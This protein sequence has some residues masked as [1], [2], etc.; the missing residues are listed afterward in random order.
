MPILLINRF[1]DL[2]APEARTRWLAD[3][4]PNCAGYHVVS[5]GERFFLYSEAAR[6]NSLIADFL[7]CEG[8]EV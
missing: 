1:D 7:A 3:H 2:L 8:P 6:V 4:L 5:G